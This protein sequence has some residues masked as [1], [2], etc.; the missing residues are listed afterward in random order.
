MLKLL[1]DGF[2]TIIPDALLNLIGFFAGRSNISYGLRKRTP[3]ELN[4][5]EIYSCSFSEFT[6]QFLLILSKIKLISRDNATVLGWTLFGWQ[7]KN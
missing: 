7:S 3:K 6:I 5:N 2:S 1:Q 4:R